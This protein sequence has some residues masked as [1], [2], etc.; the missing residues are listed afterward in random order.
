MTPL[1]G[2][3]LARAVV[4]QTLHRMDGVPSHLAI[5][6]RRTTEHSGLDAHAWVEA[7]ANGDRRESAGGG[8]ARILVTGAVSM[9]DAR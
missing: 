5:G 4:Q 9:D 7:V 8:F 1:P 6:V 3:C 2:L